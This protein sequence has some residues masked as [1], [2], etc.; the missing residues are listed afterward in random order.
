LPAYD[1]SKKFDTNPFKKKKKKK[2]SKS[3][4]ESRHIGTESSKEEMYVTSWSD[5]IDID[6]TNENSD[7][8]TRIT[9]E[10]NEIGN[11]CDRIE[12]LSDYDNLDSAETM[13]DNLEE[14]NSLIRL[15]RRKI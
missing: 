15:L 9:N 3:T 13:Q 4:K 6:I 12:K 5:W 11:I 10:V 14:I 1:M 7:I 8:D 2:K